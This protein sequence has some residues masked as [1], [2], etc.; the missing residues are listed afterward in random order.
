MTADESTANG[1]LVI[2]ER[3][4]GPTR[5]ANGGYT[6]GLLAA[7]L[8]GPAQVTL[9]RPPPL[10]RRLRVRRSADGA[11]E[12]LDGKGVI[13]AAIPARVGA[14]TPA[15]VGLAAAEAASAR[16]TGFARHPFPECFVCGPQR[17][18]TGG[19]RIFP[20]PLAGREGVA[21]PW[22]P[23]G[24]LAD[25]DGHVRSEF[26]WAAL[27]C[28]GAFASGFPAITIVLGRLAAKIRR[29]ARP[30]QPYVVVGW[31]AGA[32]GRKRFAVTALFTPDGELLAA[33][34]ATW[35]ALEAPELEALLTSAE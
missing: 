28:P 21:S 2:A 13:A 17:I 15:P 8:D 34:R 25:P 32:D 7:L 23:E 20:G 33:A 16:Y 6:A 31:P 30:G 14:A 4:R 9:R 12:L 19:L 5:S 29:P 35:I 27:D 26:I 3:F 24:S 11:V 1:D 18:E 22:V 10:A